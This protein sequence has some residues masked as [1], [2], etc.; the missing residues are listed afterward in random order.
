MIRSLVLGLS[1]LSVAVGSAEAADRPAATRELP[2]LCIVVGAGGED[3]YG[4][5]F[6]EWS[7]AWE[8][9]ATD[10]GI[11]IEIVKPAMDGSSGM[12]KER[13]TNYLKGLP[14][15]GAP[16]WIVL[17]GH[18][19][20]NSVEAKF[21]LEGPDMSADELS[22][23]LDSFDREVVVVNCTSSSGPF[24]PKLSSPKRVVVTA[25]RSGDEYNFSYFGG[26]LPAAFGDAMAD[27]DRDEQVSLLE[28]V[29]Y[30]A[31]KTR[32]FYETEGRILTEHAL[33]DDNGDDAG[34]PAEWYRGLRLTRKPVGDAVVADGMKAHQLHLVASGAEDAFSAEML[35][36]R[37]ELEN[38]VTFLRDMKSEIDV[39][40]YYRRLERLMVRMA[41]LY[42][43]AEK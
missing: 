43:N 7:G 19:T 38:Q 26:Y 32:K 10:S 20:F 23:L 37:N 39:E 8:K 21:N 14:K 24:V 41:N 35:A 6:A 40:D 29:L 3:K 25:T 11:G 2:E 18:G 33:I 15:T 4:E 42:G 28:A 9:L 17:I 34:T 5:L 31:A 36:E 13:L 27:L 22:N 16:L 1:F 12:Q 30:S